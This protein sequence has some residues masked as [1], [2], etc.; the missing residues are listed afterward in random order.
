MAEI[1]KEEVLKLARLSRLRLSNEEIDTFQDEISEI[2][3]YVEQLTAV[4]TT[5]LTPTSQVTGLQNVMREDMLID[6]K[7]TQK[8]LLKN[9]P[10]IEKNQFKVKRVLG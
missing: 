10:A 2:L 3:T 8:D 7:M 5:G 9:A 4:D 6:Y 1:S